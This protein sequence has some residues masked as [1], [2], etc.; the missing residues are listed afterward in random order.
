MSKTKW[1]VL[2]LV[3]VIVV[4]GL[5]GV[6]T[7]RAAAARQP[8]V[9]ASVPAGAAS[10]AP[11]SLPG[12]VLLYSQLDSP[13]GMATNSQNFEA[14]N[15]A[16]DNELADDFIVPASGW[17]I[18]NVTLTGL[19]FNG[20]GPA[21]TVHVAFYNNSGVLP[22]AAIVA[23]DYP[24]V[25]PGGAGANFSIA[26]APACALAAGHYWVGVIANMNFTPSGQWGWTDRTVTSNSPAAWRNPGGGFGT[27]CTPGFGARGATCGIDAA[28]PDQIFSL[29]GTVT[30]VELIDAGV[31]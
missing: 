2:A 24:A 27:P 14:A 5:A 11:Q 4:G 3:A 19:Y 23:C 7:A 17:S 13:A 26:L 10:S 25:V 21:P 28:A 1:F 12:K 6:A 18:D 22:G 20:P 29:S 31:D 16:F 9:S 15:D 30:P 8:Q